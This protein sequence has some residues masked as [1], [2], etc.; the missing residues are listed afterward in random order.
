MTKTLRESLREASREKYNEAVLDY[1][2]IAENT[3]INYMDFSPYLD[4]PF[5]WESSLSLLYLEQLG[6]R[7]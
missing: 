6:L 7:R 2:A 1:E 5:F 4:D 3:N